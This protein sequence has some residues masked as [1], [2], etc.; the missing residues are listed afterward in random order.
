M[1]D[2]ETHR[3]RV[4]LWRDGVL[5]TIE[6]VFLSLEEALA[7]GR[8]HA[9]KDDTAGIKILDADQQVVHAPYLPDLD[10]SVYA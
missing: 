9:K 5:S 1:S 2:K 6:S 7:F 10:I 3:V 4:H 8:H